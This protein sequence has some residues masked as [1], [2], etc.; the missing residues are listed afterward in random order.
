MTLEGFIIGMVF[1]GF[2]LIAMWALANVG[3]PKAQ[4]KHVPFKHRK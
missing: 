3:L 2:A 4:N 1:A